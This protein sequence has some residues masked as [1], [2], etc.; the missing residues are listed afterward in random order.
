MRTHTHQSDVVAFFKARALTLFTDRRAVQSS[1]LQ[2]LRER[3]DF[4][5]ARRG[6]SFSQ[7]FV[8]DEQAA[9]MGWTAVWQDE[10]WVLWQLPRLR[11]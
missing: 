9:R 2:V 3:S 8:T 4:F 7:P 11:A 5:L 6:S 10:R 1:D